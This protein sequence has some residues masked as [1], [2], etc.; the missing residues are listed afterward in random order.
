MSASESA[1]TRFAVF[2]DPVEHSKSPQLH[3][4]FA[5]QTDRNISYIK[6][7]VLADEFDEA[8]EHF[9]KSGGKGLNITVPL[10][11][12]AFRYAQ[13][14]TTRAQQAGAV[15]TLAVQEDGTIVGDNTDGFGLVR[16]LKKNLGWEIANKKILVLGAGGAVRGILGPLLEQNPSE[17]VVANRTEEKAEYLVNIFQNQGPIYG[18]GLDR[19]PA[20]AFDL[21]IN[22]TSMSLDGEVPPLSRAQLN[23]D[24]CCYDLAYGDKPTA[25]LQWA[26]LQG[27][28]NL[29]D[30]TGMLVEQGAESYRIWHGTRPKTKSV[31]AQLKT[32]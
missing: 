25:F 11:Q 16:D 28:K 3:Q 6:L 20:T 31:I 18:C 13:Q 21:I 22:G 5:Q 26:K 12:C 32:S 23:A 2:G 1:P 24:T 4:A 10:K 9:F 8:C 14:L 29:A 17:V 7:R 30:G 15:N 19:I 27:V